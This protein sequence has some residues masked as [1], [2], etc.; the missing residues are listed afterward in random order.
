MR[1]SLSNGI[2]NACRLTTLDHA[3]RGRPAVRSEI[4][5]LL[6][7]GNDIPKS[8]RASNVKMQFLRHRFIFFLTRESSKFRVRCGA[9][10]RA[11]LRAA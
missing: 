8:A 6:L 4:A 2:C 11:A 5:L 10:H 1:F 3:R 7:I 9:C